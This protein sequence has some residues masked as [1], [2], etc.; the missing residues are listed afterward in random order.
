MS[1]DFHELRT[2]H[3]VVY[4]VYNIR[5]YGATGG[6]DDSAAIS[7]CIED[8]RSKGG[9][10][11]YFPAGEWSAQEIPVY[12]NVQ[13]RGAGW[14]NTKIKLKN[15]A[16]YPL[17]YY[18]GS[19]SLEM[20]GWTDMML[21]GLGRTAQDGINLGNATS[22]QFSD[23]RGVRI[24]NFKEGVRGSQNDRRPFW[25]SCQFW[26]NDMGYYVINNHPHFNFCDVRDNNYGITG[27]VLYDMQIN[28]TIIIRN[29]Y[30]LVAQNGGSINQCLITNT[31]L[32]GNYIA[33]AKVNQRVHFG[34]CYLIAGVNQ[35]PGCYGVWFESNDS[36]WIGGL[37]RGEGVSGFNDCAFVIR[38]SENVMIKGVQFDIDNF[39]RTVDTQSYYRRLSITDNV[40]TT[41]GYFSK[42]AIQNANGVQMSSISNNQIDITTPT[43]LADTDGVIDLPLGSTVSGNNINGNMIQCLDAGYLPYAIKADARSSIVTHNN[44]RRTSGISLTTDANTIY[45]DNRLPNGIN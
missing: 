19:G 7:K 23:N 15:S 18:G 17:F 9:G 42:L 3:S 11:V 39:V 27:M 21:E 6:A 10:I 24:Y 30:G 29:N 14:N 36:E 26:N 28:G 2:V 44:I 41:R 37:V 35:Q 32:F 34:D 12:S 22:W 5:K 4:D 31:S 43:L 33:G 45:K 38:G 25:T 16:N 8:C 13:F 1:L 40:G 20:A